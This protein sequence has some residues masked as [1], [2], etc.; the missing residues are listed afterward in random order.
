M[1]RAPQPDQSPAPVAR[2]PHLRP[3]RHAARGTNAPGLPLDVR[4]LTAP[5][6]TWVVPMSTRTGQPVRADDRRAAP[7]TWL[8]T[9]LPMMAAATLATVAIALAALIAS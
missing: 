9:R 5:R 2:S 4:A 6:W 3:R 7:P 8:A 1:S